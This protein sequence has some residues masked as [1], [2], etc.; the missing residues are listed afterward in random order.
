M[1]VIRS[2]AIHFL[3]GFILA[4]SVRRTV[5]LKNGFSEGE[6]LRK[7]FHRVSRSDTLFEKR[8]SILNRI[9]ALLCYRGGLKC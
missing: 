9:S 2:I 4:D 7:W 3:R 8:L 1:Q 5:L 6:P